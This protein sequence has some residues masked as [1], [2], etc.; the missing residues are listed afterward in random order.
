MTPYASA[1]D[2]EAADEEERGG[3]GTSAAS[4]KKDRVLRKRQEC[5][6][7]S[8]MASECSSSA[9]LLSLRCEI[10]ACPYFTRTLSNAV[11]SV[12][13]IPSP[14]PLI[15]SAHPM[16]KLLH[17]F[18][19]TISMMKSEMEASQDEVAKLCEQSLNAWI[20]EEWSASFFEMSLSPTALPEALQDVEVSSSSSNFR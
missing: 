12:S 7:V 15:F 19:A 3:G 17:C 18:M 16:T 13:C 9:Q 10:R 2:D 5:L 11:L 14:P 8:L 1:E 4:S 20:D 6:S